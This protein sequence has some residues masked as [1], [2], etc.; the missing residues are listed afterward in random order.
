PRFFATYGIH[1]LAGRDVS[2]D[3]RNGVPPVAIV[4]ESFARKFLGGGNPVGR[5]FRGQIG[6]PTTATYQVVGLVSDAAYQRL[7]DGMMPTVYLPVTQTSVSG[8]ISLAVRSTPARRG[9]FDADL[10]RALAAV[11]ASAAF[12][13]HPFDAS[14]TA[15]LRQERLVAML[16]AFF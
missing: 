4:N 7:R 3:D 14:L 16:S 1:L 15:A 12:T 2:P 11:D 13:I 5:Q 8:W 10:T 6:M 9:S